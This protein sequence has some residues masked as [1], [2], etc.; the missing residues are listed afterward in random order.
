[1]VGIILNLDIKTRVIIIMMEESNLF[2]IHYIFIYDYFMYAISI[3][4]Y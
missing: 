1:M 4:L 2:S 3:Y